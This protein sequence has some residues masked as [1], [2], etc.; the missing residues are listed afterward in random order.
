VPQIPTQ[1]LP[2]VAPSGQ[3]APYLHVETNPNMFGAGV[4]EA[5]GRLTE[6][7]QGVHDETAARD[8]VNQYSNAQI[9]L[10][11]D[12]QNGFRV[13]QGKDAVA[14]LPDY[15]Q[16]A[17]DNYQN[18]R[19]SLQNEAQRKMFDAIAIRYL[20]GAT[21]SM[22][23]HASAE[24]ESWTKQ[25]HH[26]TEL[27]QQNIIT[28][29]PNDPEKVNQAIAALGQNAADLAISQG[30]DPATAADVAMQAGYATQIQSLGV[31]DPA[32]AR[33]A[34]EENKDRLGIF[35][36]KLDKETTDRLQQSQKIAAA[37]GI[38]GQIALSN[39]LRMVQN[40]EDQANYLLANKEKGLRMVDEQAQAMW[41][42]DAKFKQEMEQVF[43]GNFNH[44]VQALEAQQ[45]QVH[46]TL[47]QATMGALPD[48]SDR[49]KTFAQFYAEP[50]VRENWDKASIGVRESIQRH[51]ER[52]DAGDEPNPANF[53]ALRDRVLN[54]FA[55]DPGSLNVKIADDALRSHQINM[56]EYDQIVSLINSKDKPL[57][58]RLNNELHVVE[59][60]LAANPIIST[61][62]A[63][64]PNYIPNLL[65]SIQND[66]LKTIEEYRAQGK[67]ITPLLDHNSKEYLFDPAKVAAYVSPPKKVMAD[68]ADAIR[69]AGGS[70]PAAAVQ[71][72]KDHPEHKKD[73][74]AKY[75]YDPDVTSA[76]RMTT[77]TPSA[78]AG[79][80]RH[81]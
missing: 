19:G 21:E 49:P 69:A 17:N 75:G 5:G 55:R 11:A 14:A 20:H 33:A 37:D 70:A 28:T 25:T 42:G 61:L 47:V 18:F 24:M 78:A 35:A 23:S 71:F 4:A 32:A 72:V 7:F 76:P 50:G 73:F 60:R 41:P 68:Q 26:E 13:K 46:N 52:G 58:H 53:I 43:E 3:A 54:T 38:I 62:H 10:Q 63:T 12:P 80:V 27:A 6:Y 56:K 74:V 34:F 16:R 39:P 22:T 79:V 45:H 57:E 31:H 9:A 30:R 77:E 15:L 67:S 8:A 1:V 40:A 48:G 59:Q 64:D 44:E 81:L 66:S 65:I 51:F 36:D 2:D 29:Y